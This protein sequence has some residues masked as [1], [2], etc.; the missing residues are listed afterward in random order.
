MI[1]NDDA[2]AAVDRCCRVHVCS[3]TRVQAAGG[4]RTFI[5]RPAGVQVGESLGRLFCWKKKKVNREY[6]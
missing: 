3:Y 6:R 1:K 5:G 2:A 4:T